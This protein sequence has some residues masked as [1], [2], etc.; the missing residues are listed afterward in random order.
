VANDLYVIVGTHGTVL[1]SPDLQTWTN[2]GGITGKALYGLAATGD[3]LVAVGVEGSI[4]RAA[5][6]VP[7]PPVSFL[8]YPRNAG[9]NVF[10]FAGA[11]DRLFRLDRSSDLARWTQGP[12]LELWE[13]DG[14]LIHVDDAVHQ[15]QAQFFRATPLP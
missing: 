14:M 4:L 8:F 3:Q 9:E 11:P 10:L 6:G 15:E 13:D 5:L 2:V 1:T 7:P 12:I